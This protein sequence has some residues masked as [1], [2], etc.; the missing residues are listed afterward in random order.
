MRPEVAGR[1]FISAARVGFIP[2]GA[3]R[4]NGSADWLTSAGPLRTPEGIRNRKYP[5]AFSLAD[6]L[7]DQL[8]LAG[9]GVEIHVDDLLPRAQDQPPAGEGD[10]QRRAEQ[11]GAQV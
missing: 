4:S 1:I 8:P 11:R 9:T 7:N 2:R 5:R 3:P 6:E 10:G